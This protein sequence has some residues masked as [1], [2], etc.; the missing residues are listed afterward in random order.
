MNQRWKTT[1][2]KATTNLHAAIGYAVLSSILEKIIMKEICDTFD[3]HFTQ[4]YF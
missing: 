2:D 4:E 3:S 1:N